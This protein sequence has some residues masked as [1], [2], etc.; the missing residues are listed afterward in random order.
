MDP[1]KT[2][3]ALYLD[4]LMKRIEANNGHIYKGYDGFFYLMIDIKSNGAETCKVLDN[5]L[6]RYRSVLSVTNDTVEEKN[7]PVK[8]FISGNRTGKPV[9]SFEK[10]NY[11]LFTLDG[12]PEDLGKNIP[13]VLMPVV[14]Q[15]YW[16]MMS[17]DGNGKI[18]PEEE[19][20]LE[21]FIAKAHAE[22][23][24]TRL[25]GEPDNPAVWKLFLDKG[26][27]LINTDKLPEL[28]AFLNT[29]H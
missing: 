18:K 16:K 3:Q 28:A 21:D 4:P 14:S 1:S 9:G 24:K 13:S 23:K 22:G 26:M 8:I 29:N 17:W 11:H 6:Q 15:D 20:K 5:L 19:K 25:W 7:K 27:D 12:R 2:L 10:E